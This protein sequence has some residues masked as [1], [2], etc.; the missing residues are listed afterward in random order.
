MGIPVLGIIHCKFNTLSFIHIYWCGTDITCKYSKQNKLITKSLSLWSVTKSLMKENN[1]AKIE[2]LRSAL[3]LNISYFS[4]DT[5]MWFIKYVRWSK[6]ICAAPTCV[7]P[8]LHLGRVLIFWK[9]NT[10]PTSNIV[11]LGP[12]SPKIAEITSVVS[13]QAISDLRRTQA[14]P[15]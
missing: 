5:I 9:C 3:G 7:V 15:K 2:C 8:V 13:Q 12:R 11:D 14:Y 1:L 4:E 10:T 6:H